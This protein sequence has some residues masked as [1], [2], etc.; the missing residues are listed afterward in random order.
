MRAQNRAGDEVILAPDH[1]SLWHDT[2]PAHM[3]VEGKHLYTLGLKKCGCEW[4]DRRIGCSQK[5]FH[6]VTKRQG[7]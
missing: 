4:N 3:D 5:F 1:Q 7:S 2:Q 6:S